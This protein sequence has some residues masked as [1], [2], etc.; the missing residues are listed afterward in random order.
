MK[1]V[2]VRDELHRQ[3][4]VISTEEGVPLIDVLERFVTV[5]LR[6]YRRQRL[7]EEKVHEL[8]SSL[9]AKV[10]TLPNR[11][12]TFDAEHQRLFTETAQGLAPTIPTMISDEGQGE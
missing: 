1:S 10:S 7:A 3:L 12:F 6:D 11:D 8:V 2:Y 5:G 9:R 4:K